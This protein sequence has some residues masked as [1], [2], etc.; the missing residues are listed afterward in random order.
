MGQTKAEMK[1]AL[2]AQ[3]SDALDELLAAN[4][5]IEGFADLEE[6]VSQLAERTLPQTLGTLLSSKDF[7][8]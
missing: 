8:P 5:Q 6:A 3:Y 1:A 2:L 7:S 4:E